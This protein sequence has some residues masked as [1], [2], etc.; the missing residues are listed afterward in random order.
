MGG[1]VPQTIPDLLVPQ[2]VDARIK[3]VSENSCLQGDSLL[4]V[5][6]KLFVW[7]YVHEDGTAIEYGSHSDV[8][9]TSGEGLFPA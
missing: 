5:E 7:R 1:S 8:G 4:E 3:Q 9:G 2:S 6:G